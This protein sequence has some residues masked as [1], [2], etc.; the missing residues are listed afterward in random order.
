MIT[1]GVVLKLSL[2][3][4]MEKFSGPGGSW[5]RRSIRP[6]QALADPEWGRCSCCNRSPSSFRNSGRGLFQ[7]AEG[8]EDA[9]QCDLIPV[10]GYNVIGQ[11]DGPAD[12][13]NSHCLA[14]HLK[15]S[16]AALRYRAHHKDV[17]AYA[18][19]VSNKA[20]ERDALLRKRF[21]ELGR[22]HGAGTI[23]AR[24]NGIT[25][26]AMS[27]VLRRAFG[28]TIPYLTASNEPLRSP[29]KKNEQ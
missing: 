19:L 16:R 3:R 29:K 11:E 12:L 2:W 23:I 27:L 25:R 15:M 8:T 17:G 7:Y 10:S 26:Q 24:E 14:K 4:K 5:Y 21:D 9:S 22:L 28:G 6:A 13:C 20:A 18:K 1:E